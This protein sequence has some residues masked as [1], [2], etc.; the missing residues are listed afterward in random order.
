LYVKVGP[1][2]VSYVPAANGVLIKG[3]ESESESFHVV[4]FYVKKG[5]AK[6]LAA[7][8]VLEGKELKRLDGSLVKLP[9]R[10]SFYDPLE[11]VEVEVSHPTGDVKTAVLG[12]SYTVEFKVDGVPLRADVSDGSVSLSTTS[13]DLSEGFVKLVNFTW[14]RKEDDL[15]FKEGANDE[16]VEVSGQVPIKFGSEV[17]EVLSFLGFSE[18]S[19]DDGPEVIK[20]VEED[21]EAYVL[22]PNLKPSRYGTATA[23]KVELIPIS[24]ELENVKHE[25]RLN[26]DGSAY[27]VDADGIHA[28]GSAIFDLE[29]Q[30]EESVSENYALLSVEL[31]QGE[32]TNS[33][34]YPVLPSWIH[35]LVKFKKAV[36]GGNPKAFDEVTSKLMLNYFAEAFEL[37]NGN[38]VPMKAYS[39]RSLLEEL[40]K[41]KKKGLF[42]LVAKVKKGQEVVPLIGVP[43][44]LDS[45]GKYSLTA[46]EVEGEVKKQVSLGSFDY[47]VVTSNEAVSA[48]E[49]L[50][51]KLTFKRAGNKVMYVG[52]EIAEAKGKMNLV[53]VKEEAKGDEVV[54][55]VSVTAA[56]KDAS[57]SYVVLYDPKALFEALGELKVAALRAFGAEA[58]KVSSL[59]TPLPL[60]TREV[61][62]TSDGEVTPIYT[63]KGISSEGMAVTASID[64]SKTVSV[65]AGS[66]RYIAKVKVDSWESSAVLDSWSEGGAAAKLSQSP[67][68]VL[69]NTLEFK[70]SMS[71]AVHG[72]YLKDESGEELSVVPVSL[73]RINVKNDDVEVVIDDA[74]KDLVEKVYVGCPPCCIYEVSGS[75]VISVSG[76]GAS[77]SKV[78]DCTFAEPA[79]VAKVVT[80]AQTVIANYVDLTNLVSVTASL[81]G[82]FTLSVQPKV[83]LASEFGVSAYGN[84]TVVSASRGSTVSVSG[85]APAVVVSYKCREC[86]VA[87]AKAGNV[88]IKGLEAAI[89]NALNSGLR[90]KVRCKAGNSEL[91]G[92]TVE[93]KEVERTDGKDVSGIVPGP[94]EVT[95]MVKCSDL[96]KFEDKTK[97]WVSGYVVKFEKGKLLVA[98]APPSESGKAEVRVEGWKGGLKDVLMVAPDVVRKEEG[99][100]VYLEVEGI[101]TA[102]VEI[103]IKDESGQVIEQVSKIVEDRNNGASG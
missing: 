27:K 34:A 86:N 73:I 51:V 77:A 46:T 13:D 72:K 70:F 54:Y 20:V 76:L 4:N 85:R 63:V 37:A 74:L 6:R 14:L 93:V 11:A 60:A 66:T 48:D 67:L 19:V 79:V 21:R 41:E 10:I 102:K 9:I 80:N 53:S 47:K 89:V 45:K 71:K 61:F 31:V 5:E 33:K 28:E 36:D 95:Y 25:I 12:P 94:Y 90:A 83:P 78:M 58:G 97:L 84:N 29:G 98:A 92:S 2:N 52:Y 43:V 62:V 103:A 30:L 22:V 56:Y 82:E 65:A 49:A 1:V 40:K 96:L 8:Y 50:Q 42:Y 81:A 32:S 69:A 39:L 75:S 3:V 99:S 68:F 16:V 91:E 15:E 88:V 24:K 57:G 55:E 26:E 100:S 18:A 35:P 101:K 59:F 44:A 87:F 64:S 38:V 23:L 7:S 17:D